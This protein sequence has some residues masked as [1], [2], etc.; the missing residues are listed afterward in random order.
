[1]KARI[2]FSYSSLVIF[3]VFVAPLLVGRAIFIVVRR[4]VLSA[5][6]FFFVVSIDGINRVI[7]PHASM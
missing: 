5:N 6:L 1:M 7:Q 2:F 4:D 3:E